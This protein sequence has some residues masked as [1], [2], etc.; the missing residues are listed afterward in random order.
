MKKK[1]LIIGYGSIGKRHAYILSKKKKFVKN[2][3][4]LTKQNCEPFIKVN[5]FEKIALINPD[6]IIISSPTS[7]H[8]KQLSFLEKTLSRKLILVEKTLFSKN[9]NLNI[10]KNK[11][12]VGYNMRFN[13]LIQ[14]IKNKIKNKKI[15]SIN[16]FCG[17]YLPH[18]RKG[19]DYRFT[20]SAKKKLGGGV[21]L[22]LS[23]ELDYIRW[24]LGNIQLD[25]VIS[26]KLSDLKI[27]T[28]DFL[29]ISGTAN[30]FT[31]VQIDLNYFTKKPTRRII[32]D[33][34]NISIDAD[35]IEK[36]I[37][38]SEG[39]NNGIFSKKSLHKN[40]TYENMHRSL[41]KKDFK[42]CCSYK[43]GKNLM[44][45]ID[46]IKKFSK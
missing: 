12:F 5:S 17:S 38:F 34:K 27:D 46:K 24:L 25:N 16:V 39:E 37:F 33:G 45:L 22:D 6:Y 26:R 32:I 29:S 21:L 7:K 40:H 13:P 35:L 44:L 18:W 11:V 14:F 19:R 4:I 1:I 20:S 9:E 2:I 8:Y 23:H 15:W 41:L 10:K 43:E 30:K 28:D 36:K 42:V 3:Y 31:R